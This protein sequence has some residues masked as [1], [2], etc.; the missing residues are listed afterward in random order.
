MTEQSSITP[1]ET[2][3]GSATRT[4]PRPDR[5]RRAVRADVGDRAHHPP[6]LGQRVAARHTV[7][8]H[9]RR[10]RDRAGAAPD[11]GAWLVVLAV[12]Q[13]VDLVAEMPYSPDHWM[14]MAF[15][16]LAILVTMAWRRSWSLPAPSAAF[17]APR[18]WCSLLRGGRAGEV[19][20]Q[21]PRPGHQLRDRDRRGGELGITTRLDIGPVWVVS[22]L[23][24]ETLIPLLLAVPR[25]RRHGVRLGLA[26]HFMLSASPAFAVVDFTAALFA[27]FVLFLGDRR[28][29]PSSTGSGGS[30]SRS[31]VVRDAVA[32][33]WVTAAVALLA[34][35]FLGY[36]SGRA[37]TAIVLLAQRDLPARDPGGRPAAPGG[38]GP[39]PGRSGDSCGCR[40]R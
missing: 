37:V 11:L 25:T 13:L 8:H 1:S 18:T 27:L 28:S 32:K 17:P 9:G 2:R 19:Q 14:L 39:G 26:F 24:C 3:P 38:R 7:E 33:P 22:V 16:N 31:A 36:L 20:H 12:A 23:A 4:R 21:L 10:R 40:S 15:A 30:P 34:F 29:T 5:C 35:G 6:R